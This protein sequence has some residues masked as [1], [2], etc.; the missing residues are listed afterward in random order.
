MGSNSQIVRPVYTRIELLCSG[1]RDK[2][3]RR[4]HVF[5]FRQ[6]RPDNSPRFILLDNEIRTNMGIPSVFQCV[7]EFSSFSIKY[8]PKFSSF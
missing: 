5:S 7:Y 1:R 4:L 3:K 2:F 8:L 6:N